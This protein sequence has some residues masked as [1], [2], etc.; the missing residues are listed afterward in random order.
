MTLLYVSLKG[1]GPSTDANRDNKK[2]A[3][4][5]R[6]FVQSLSESPDLQKIS[7]S[8]FLAFDASSTEWEFR[9][10]VISILGLKL[11]TG[12]P[13]KNFHFHLNNSAL[14]LKKM[15]LLRLR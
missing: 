6:L 9:F 13:Q 3:F 2:T 1:G 4:F 7:F 11:I 8:T 5:W 12:N 10:A 15:G 14:K